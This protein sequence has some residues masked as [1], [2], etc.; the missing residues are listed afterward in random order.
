[1]TKKPY[2]EP[3]SMADV[4]KPVMRGIRPKRRDPTEKL[5]SVWASVVGE[6]TASRTRVAAVIDGEVVV[7][8][9]SAALRQHLGVFLCEEILQDL[10]AALPDARITGLK[11]RVVGGL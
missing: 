9:S 6:K 3:V 1:V 5:R 11:C 2:R 7:E 8:V 10:R 4:L